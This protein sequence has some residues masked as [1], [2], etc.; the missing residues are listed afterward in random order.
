MLTDQLLVV[1]VEF[2]APLLPCFFREL[3]P[4]IIRW[5]RRCVVIVSIPGDAATMEVPILTEHD[6]IHSLL[7][8]LCILT[9]LLAM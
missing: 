7:L 2:I 4:W 1:G 5:I 6:Q 3:P 8:R 9:L